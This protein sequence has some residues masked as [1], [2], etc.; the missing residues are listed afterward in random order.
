MVSRIPVR[1]RTAPDLHWVSDAESNFT[2]RSRKNKEGEIIPEITFRW[3][4]A[5]FEFL[6][7]IALHKDDR[8]TLEY[9]Q[10]KL[11]CGVIRVD[12]NNYVLIISNFQ[13][14]EF[15]LLPVFEEFHLNSSQ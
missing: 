11:D 6:F 7:R 14:I 10:S 12:R 9:I 13:D 5:G 2:I 15:K 3:F 4:W 1:Y 8:K